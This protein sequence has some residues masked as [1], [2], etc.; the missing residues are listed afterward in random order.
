MKFV[1][2]L[3]KAGTVQP[4]PVSAPMTLRDAQDAIDTANAAIAAKSARAFG[5]PVGAR[6]VAL[7]AECFAARA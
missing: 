4:V 6:Y 2:A 5:A 7:N 3:I 1:V